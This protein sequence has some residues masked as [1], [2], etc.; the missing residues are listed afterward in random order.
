MADPR[1][2]V[3][4]A[5]TSGGGGV[6]TPILVDKFGVVQVST[7]Q[8]ITTE[9]ATGLQLNV[10]KQAL[11]VD[12]LGG[13]FVFTNP[14]APPPALLCYSEIGTQDFN[15]GNITT[16]ISNGDQDDFSGGADGFLLTMSIPMLWNGTQYDRMREATVYH[17]AFVTASGTTAVWTPTAGTSFRLMGYSI[18][19]AGTAAATGV[20]HIELLDSATVI[21]NH[22]ATVLQTFAPTTAL[23]GVTISVDLG[24]GQLSAAPDNVLNVNLSEAMAS[25]GVAVNVWGTEE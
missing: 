24:Q 17:T 22:L 9:P 8:L 5:A 2:V 6:L 20:Q 18:D 1:Y 10:E 4:L 12:A 23:Q 25:G 3:S 15:T 14:S 7:P 19:I 13:S 21:K 16:A 11:L